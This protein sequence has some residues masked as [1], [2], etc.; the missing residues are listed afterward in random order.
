MC[1]FRS[2]Q[3][4]CIRNTLL[5]ALRQI[6]PPAN[7]HEVPSNVIYQYPTV[8]RLAA[9]SAQVSR[10]ETA[11]E[12]TDTEE[13]RKTRLLELLAKYT[14]E[15]PEYTPANDA[16]CPTHEIIL[17]TG[18]TGGLGSQVLAHFVVMPSVSYIRVQ[19]TWTEEFSK[20]TRGGIPGPR[21]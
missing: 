7:V 2:L 14:H 12:N 6:A 18:S 17:L 4:T 11:F 10:S 9:F 1:S 16:V 19:Q 5:H 8:R 21:Q 13:T 20:Q 15:W 3:A